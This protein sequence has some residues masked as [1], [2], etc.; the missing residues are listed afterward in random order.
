MYCQKKQSGYNVK[1]LLSPILPVK[2][3][4]L[5]LSSILIMVHIPLSINQPE[6]LFFREI[7]AEF[8]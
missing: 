2:F 6:K 7:E 1:N 5:A 8:D 3:C 4:R